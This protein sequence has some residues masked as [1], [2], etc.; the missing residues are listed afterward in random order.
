MCI[1]FGVQPSLSHIPVVQY[2]LVSVQV[3]FELAPIDS[4][5]YEK[6]SPLYKNKNQ[7]MELPVI[8]KNKV[9]KTIEPTDCDWK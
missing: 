2:Y 7:P 9:T 1:H 4:L 8:Q 5:Q 3:T 6:P